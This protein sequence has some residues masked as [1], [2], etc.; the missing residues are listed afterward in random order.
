MTEEQLIYKINQQLHTIEFTDVIG[1]IDACYD[2]QP[3][4]FTNGDLINNIV[5]QPGENKG[6]CKIFA[7]AMLHHLS[8]EQTLH[9]FGKY[10]RQDVLK[11]PESGSHANIRQFMRTGWQG[12]NYQDNALQK[13]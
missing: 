7:F 8:V 4:L 13:K 2:Y 12:I 10:Y 3:T 1:V 6:S 5:N 11:H 9:C